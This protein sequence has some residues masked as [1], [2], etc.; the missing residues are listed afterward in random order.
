MGVANLDTLTHRDGNALDDVTVL[1]KRRLVVL[2]DASMRVRV[3]LR[4]LRLYLMLRA[5]A[6]CESLYL[7]SSRML[8]A[9]ARCECV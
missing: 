1:E 2:C 7:I 9:C 8:R 4:A 5:C 3:N 6:R